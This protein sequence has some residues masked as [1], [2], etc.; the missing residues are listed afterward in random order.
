MPFGF[1][2]LLLCALAPLNAAEHAQILS[3]VVDSLFNHIKS[4]G[5]RKDGIPTMTNPQTVDPAQAHY[6]TDDDQVMGVYINGEARAYPHS[7]GWNHEIVNDRIGGRYISVTFCPLTSTGLVFDATDDQGDQI[8][9]GVSGLLINSNLVM[10]NRSNDTLY[11]QMIFTGINGPDKGHALTLLPVVE[12]TWGLWKKL[13][14]STQIAQAATGLERYED[15]IRELYKPQR[16]Q[17]YPY[18]DYRTDHH[19]LMFMPTTAPYNQSLPAKDIVLGVFHRDHSKAYPLSRMPDGAVIN[20]RLG[21]RPLLIIF[22]AASRTAIPYLR[23]IQNRTLSFYKVPGA[24]DLPVEF[25]DR[26]TASRWNMRGE[27]VAGPLQGEQL[28]QMPSYNAM[29]FGWS[30]YWPAT[31]LWDGEGL[32][33]APE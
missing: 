22:D 28:E 21:D 27:A 9:F 13:Y 17:N 23:Q 8:E 26:E 18:G 25:M 1:F 31:Q 20:D 10:F 12:T 15:Y 3:V 29:W 30:A 19:A 7:L 4:G 11:P 5:V 32:L 14:P 16:Y 33:G 2:A 24:D 6:L